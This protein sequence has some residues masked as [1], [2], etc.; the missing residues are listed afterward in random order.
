MIVICGILCRAC[1]E[2]CP[3]VLSVDEKTSSRQTWSGTE[4]NGRSIE[5]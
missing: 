2:Q 4:D 3:R 1:A 5:I